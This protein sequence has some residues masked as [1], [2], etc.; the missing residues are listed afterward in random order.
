LVT[1]RKTV[2]SPAHLEVLGGEQLFSEEFQ[3]VLVFHLLHVEEHTA[4]EDA[5][6]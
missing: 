3:S 5:T 2:P 6:A 1:G 4:N